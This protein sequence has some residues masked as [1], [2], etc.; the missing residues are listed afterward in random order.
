M[1][2]TRNTKV[3]LLLAPGLILVVLFFIIPA[4]MTTIMSFTDMDFR[5]KW[6]FIGI[7]NFYNII[8]DF[9]VPR[10]I[11]N[12]AIYLFWTLGVFNVGLSL[13]LAIFTTSIGKKPGMFYK[14][15]FL[16]PRFTPPVVY[17]SIWMLILSPTKNGLFNGILSIFGIDA[18]NWFSEYPMFS[19]ILI[20]G[21][22]GTSLGML[23]FSS[24][25]ESIPGDYIK[26]AQV[27]GASWLQTIIHIKLPIIRWP[28]LFILA[29]NSL[30]LL[31]SYEYIMLTTDGGPFYASEVWALYAYH[32]AFSSGQSSTSFRFGYGAAFSVFLVIIGIIASVI[33][34]RVFKFKDMM[35]EPQIEVN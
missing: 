31:T 14:A 32:L 8:K 35:K 13:V 18:I 17:A 33:Y 24:A 15:I 2:K 25:I 27:D 23:V 4:I 20:N 12:T 28:L 34:W 5:L 16:L 21:F 10:I 22:I 11:S 30:S 9:L 1:K 29:Y 6:D 7:A 26:A 3:F 19:I